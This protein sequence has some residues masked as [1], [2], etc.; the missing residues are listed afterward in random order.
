MTEP[1]TR[2]TGVIAGIS[3]KQCK[4]PSA[5]EDDA[6]DL[7]IDLH[8]PRGELDRLNRMIIADVQRWTTPDVTA[9]PDGWSRNLVAVR[10]E[11]CP[12]ILPGGR[13][14]GRHADWPHTHPAGTI[15]LVDDGAE[16]QR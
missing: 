9:D 1:E 12:A 2:Q 14:C 16:F 13:Q 15:A 3:V 8:L 5:V 10:G 7:V 6:V 11:R 4:H